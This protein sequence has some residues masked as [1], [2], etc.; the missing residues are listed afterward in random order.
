MNKKIGN[1]AVVLGASMAGL[2]AA[3]VLAESYQQVIVIDRDQLP[4]T[5]RHRRGVP[6]GRHIHAL[7]AGANKFWRSCS[8]G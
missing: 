7:A 4:E 5:A 3:R 8:Q 6:Q 2:L 1:R